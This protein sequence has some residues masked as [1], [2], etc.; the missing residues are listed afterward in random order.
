MG[1]EHENA[2][3]D[4]FNWAKAWRSRSSGS[5]DREPIDVTCDVAVIEC[6][7]TEKQSYS[8]KKTF[9]Q[10]IVEKQ[11]DGKM[12]MLGIRF[13]DP[14]SDKHTDLAVMSLADASAILEELEALRTL[15]LKR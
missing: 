15:A 3:V 4:S 9:W 13:R 14:T 7:A 12:P 8:L 10:E 1:Q 6:E 11:Y 5:S 2:V